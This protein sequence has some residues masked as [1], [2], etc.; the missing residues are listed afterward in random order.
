MKEGLGIICF[1]ETFIDTGFIEPGK[2]LL[3]VHEGQLGQI[4]HAFGHAIQDVL[5][6]KEVVS[7]DEERQVESIFGQGMQGVVQGVFNFD[8]IFVVW[9]IL[10]F[11]YLN[12]V[13]LYRG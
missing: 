8:L 7:L 9:L 12:L 6:L 3:P 11:D 4:A 13:V 2:I 10:I 1:D 5:F